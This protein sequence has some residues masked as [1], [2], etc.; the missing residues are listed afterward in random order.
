MGCRD[1]KITQY[2][3]EEPSS[4]T[5]VVSSTFRHCNATGLAL[6]ERDVETVCTSNWTSCPHFR[7]PKVVDI[8]EALRTA[9][10]K[11]A[12]KER[13]TKRWWQFFK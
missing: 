6:S 4:G 2:S 3:T 9:V 10:E 5:R 12:R 13:A 8:G 11:A 1:L 7:T